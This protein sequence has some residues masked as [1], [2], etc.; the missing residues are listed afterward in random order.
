MAPL[1]WSGLGV[2]R[3]GNVCLISWGEL[4]YIDANIASL[5]F[6]I[7]LIILLTSCYFHYK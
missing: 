7:M 1:E 6:I 5:N 2:Y 3:T 4:N